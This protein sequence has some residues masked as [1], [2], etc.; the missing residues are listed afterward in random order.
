MDSA[1]IVQGGGTTGGSDFHAALTGLALMPSNCSSAFRAASTSARTR[2]TVFFVS[3]SLN[4]YKRGFPVQKNSDTTQTLY[5]CWPAIPV[6]TQ[7]DQA[8]HGPH[9]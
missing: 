9:M 5:V 7:Q 6:C 3:W 8:Y 2:S 4:T 1:G